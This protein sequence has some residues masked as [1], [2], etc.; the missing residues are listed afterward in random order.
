MSFSRS[1]PSARDRVSVHG[2]K[3][4]RKRLL[5]GASS[6]KEILDELKASANPANVEG[7]VRFGINPHN[8]L[9][10]SVTDLRKMAKEIGTDYTLAGEL[11]ASGIHEARILAGLVHDP[12]MLTESQMERWVRE[13]DSWDVCDLV[14]SSLFDKTPFAHRK[15]VEWSGKEEEFVKRAGFVM[16]AALSVHD[17]AVSDPVFERFLPL[18]RKASTDDRNFVKKAVNWAL[19]QIGKRNLALN[20]KAIE[21]AER[22]GR[23]DSPSARWI[24]MDALRELKSEAVQD[25]LHKRL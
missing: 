6:A 21:A 19:R 10:V 8:T 22:I 1:N 4:E 7:M 15:A 24:A 5:K 12:A 13:F 9:G 11:W 3:S 17:K 16:M 23:L 14:C 18:I 20:K 2:L 25:R